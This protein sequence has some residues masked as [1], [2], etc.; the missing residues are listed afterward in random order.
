MKFKTNVNIKD[1]FRPLGETNIEPHTVQ[2]ETMH[3]KVN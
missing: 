3:E 2:A 1:M